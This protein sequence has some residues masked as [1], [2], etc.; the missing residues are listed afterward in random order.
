MTHY[1]DVNDRVSEFNPDTSPSLMNNLGVGGV[2]IVDDNSAEVAAGVTPG[3]G[4]GAGKDP[5]D[6]TGC[7]EDFTS[8][9]PLLGSPHAGGFAPHDNSRAWQNILVPVMLISK[10]S[11]D[12]LKKLLGAKLTFIPGYGMQYLVNNGSGESDRDENEVPMEVPVMDHSRRIKTRI[13]NLMKR[14][15]SSE[16]VNIPEL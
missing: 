15:I 6:G 13:S 4:Y 7:N 14:G 1:N 2:V 10:S 16:S 9:H 3:Y 12:K 5:W 11:G 8:C